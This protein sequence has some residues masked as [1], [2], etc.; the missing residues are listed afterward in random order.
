MS[1]FFL[2]IFAILFTVNALAFTPLTLRYDVT[3]VPGATG[4][5]DPDSA[6][7]SVG[8]LQA[9]YNPNL[10][11]FLYCVNP[12]NMAD[13]GTWVA[14]MPEPPY[15]PSNSTLKNGAC[16]CDT[17]YNENTYLRATTC[18]ETSSWSK[19]KTAA[20]AAGVL[21]LSVLAAAVGCVF[22]A[23]IACAGLVSLAVTSAIISIPTISGA[24]DTPS[25]QSVQSA[26]SGQPL[27]VVLSPTITPASNSPAIARD[28]SGN[29]TTSGSGWSSAGSVSTLTRSNPDKG[30]QET[31]TVDTKTDTAKRVVTTPDSTTTSYISGS[32]GV[33]GG[34]RIV[35]YT[36]SSSTGNG[37]TTDIQ[38]DEK[39]EPS[40]V[41]QATCTGSTCQNSTPSSSSTGTGTG[42]STGTGTGS[43]TS[44]G[45]GSSTGTGTGTGTSTGS[46]TGTTGTSTG[47]GDCVSFGCATEATLKKIYDFF[48]GSSSSS[49]NDLPEQTPTNIFSPVGDSVD[50]FMHYNVPT[51]SSQCPTWHRV[52][53]ISQWSFNIDIE[54][55]CQLIEEHRSFIYNTAMLG[56]TIL[57]VLIILGA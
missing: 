19:I 24:L 35:T 10:Y 46:G 8:F 25:T 30:I 57:V 11:G 21:G 37:T 16:V 18:T 55:H 14:T 50:S 53:T 51:H 48:T 34:G 29:L 22:T 28:A 20:T 2:L 15:C 40:T 1:R 36:V 7:M 27:Q 43:G 39:G 52:I 23:G 4:F 47:N 3:N 38:F 49:M 12:P 31:T 17:G 33:N 32:G 13:S 5:T 26:P 42:T 44:T 9:S 41:T 6:C 54:A 56:W 45:T